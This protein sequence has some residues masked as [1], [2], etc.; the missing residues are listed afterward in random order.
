VVFTEGSIGDL[1]Y[2]DNYFDTINCLDVLEHT[3]DPAQIIKEFA[4]VIKP[5]GRVFV[6]APTQYGE[7]EQRIYE[8]IEGTL[9]PA[10]LHMHHF[11]P[12]SLTRL[13]AQNGFREVEVVPFDLMRWEEFIE[14]ADRS[15][16]LELAQELKSHPF[17]E[18]ALQLFAVYEKI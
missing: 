15:P 12:V 3:Y 16:S 6:T 4:R 14:I 11:D 8:S 10:M 18:V 17:E 5:G 7:I 2:G 9:F 1:P 13:F